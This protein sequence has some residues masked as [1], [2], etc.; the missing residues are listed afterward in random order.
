MA[1]AASGKGGGKGNGPASQPAQ[2]SSGN[3]SAGGAFT[4]KADQHLPTFDNAQRNYKEFRKRCE[5]YRKKMELAGRSA[6]TIFNIV[7]LLTGKSWD[8]ID[9]LPVEILQDADGYQRVFE[10]LDRAIK[11]DALT[12]LPDDF[13]NFFVRL[14][15]RPQQTLQVLVRLCQGRETASCHPQCGL[16]RQG[17]GLVAFQ[18]VR[19]QQRAN[20]GAGNLTIEATQKAMYFIL[21]QDSKMEWRVRGNKSDLYYQDEDDDYLDDYDGDEAD[22]AY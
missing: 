18:K 15:R 11:L 12:E 17:E 16:A 7:T 6:E 1:S 21:G 14:K 3:G 13:E 10:R 2:G 9:D 5:I 19:H 22:P 4:G 20:I 8:V